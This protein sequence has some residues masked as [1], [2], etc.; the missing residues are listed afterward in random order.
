VVT[1][2]MQS[3]FAIADRVAL[4]HEGDFLVT[5]TPAEV[6]ACDH[7]MV[8]RFLDR[9]PSETLEGAHGL[10]RFLPETP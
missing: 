8:R 4:M 9:Q 5:G 3:A 6:R 10:R 7:P 1:H 2:E